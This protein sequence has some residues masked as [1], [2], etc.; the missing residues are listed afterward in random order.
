MWKIEDFDLFFSGRG[1]VVGVVTSTNALPP[2]TKHTK[3]RQI[4]ADE[5]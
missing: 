2:I 4:Y 1:E 5:M 3:S